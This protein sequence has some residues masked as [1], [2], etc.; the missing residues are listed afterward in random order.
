MTMTN[1]T[2]KLDQKLGKFFAEQKMRRKVVGLALSGELILEG[3]DVDVLKQI[4]QELRR[5]RTDESCSK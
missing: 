3:V 5:E 4:V 2:I 1:R